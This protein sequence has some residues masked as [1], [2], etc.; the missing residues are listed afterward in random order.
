ME[1]FVVG[2]LGA[3]PPPQWFIETVLCGYVAY[4]NEEYIENNHNVHTNLGLQ[5][6]CRQAYNFRKC[7]CTRQ[8]QCIYLPMLVV[9]LALPYWNDDIELKYNPN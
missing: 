3:D 4:E 6:I 7:L 5:I 8:D 9:L 1:F 2:T